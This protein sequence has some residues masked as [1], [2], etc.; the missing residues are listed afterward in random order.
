MELRREVPIAEMGDPPP[1]D[2]GPPMNICA[3]CLRRI[4]RS[5]YR[6]RVTARRSPAG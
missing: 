3:A 6:A 2:E 4:I 1:M 5:L